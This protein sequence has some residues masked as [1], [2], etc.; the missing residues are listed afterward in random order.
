M[1]KVVIDTNVFISSRLTNTGNPA[2]VMR[3]IV[4]RDIELYFSRAILNEYKRVLAYERFKFNPIHQLT[5]L[6]DVKNI[7]IFIEPS[8]SDIPMLDES[9][10]KF[11]DAAKAVNAY[12][13]TGNLKHYPEEPHIV[14]P[15]R[16]VEL[17]AMGG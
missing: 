8:Q 12:L 9:D 7:G 2:T 15:A 4:E 1:Y 10:R 16:F 17:F 13:V 11:Y 3:L 6:D 5:A 14:S